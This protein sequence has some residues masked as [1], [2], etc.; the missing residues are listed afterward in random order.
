MR[1]RI[2][3]KWEIVSCKV[4]ITTC[5]LGDWSK[6]S[7]HTLPISIRLNLDP[8][9]DKPIRRQTRRLQRPRHRAR[10]N[11]DFALKRGEALDEALAELGALLDAEVGESRVGDGRVLWDMD[12]HVCFF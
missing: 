9:I 8:S 5:I 2:R 11:G 3:C 7:Q 12:E 1:G 4:K 10:N 6:S